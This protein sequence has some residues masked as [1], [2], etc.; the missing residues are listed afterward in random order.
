MPDLYLSVVP[1]PGDNGVV[2]LRTDPD[3]HTDC[4]VRDAM[5]HAIVEHYASRGQHPLLV[6]L[7]PGESLDTL[8]EEQ[9]AA[10][11]WVRRADDR[12]RD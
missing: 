9:M 3:V 1:D 12:R 6:L 8:D 11:G 5:A 10:S 4:D 7:R 2:V